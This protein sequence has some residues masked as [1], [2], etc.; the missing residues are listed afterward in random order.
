WFAPTIFT[1]VSTA[2]R[3]A[4]DEIFGPVLSILSFRTPAE[5]IAKANNTP[6]GLS[7]GIWSS[8]GSRVLAVA[9]K[10]RAGVVWANTFNQFDPSSPF[11]GYKESGYGREGGKQGLAAYLAPASLSTGSSSR[12]SV[13][14]ASVAAEIDSGNVEP[15]AT[16]S[17]P[18]TLTT[19]TEGS[20]K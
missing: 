19:A 1:N 12:G 14:R 4:R 6:Y 10:L 8:N 13:E 9:D 7:A 20:G 15:P 16:S 3:I 11:G 2:S 18:S 17:T 5:A